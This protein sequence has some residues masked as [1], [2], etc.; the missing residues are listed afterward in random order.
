[1]EYD[2]RRMICLITTGCSSGVFMEVNDAEDRDDGSLSTTH[3]I[4][5]ER[6]GEDFM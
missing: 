6:L 1:M 4:F 5:A 2:E 3:C